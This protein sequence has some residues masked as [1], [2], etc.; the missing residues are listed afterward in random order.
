MHGVVSIE[1]EVTEV[2]IIIT[3]MCRQVV[4]TYLAGQSMYVTRTSNI[5]MY[6]YIIIYNGVTKPGDHAH[7]ERAGLDL[8]ILY[9]GGG[10]GLS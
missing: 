2:D 6:V 5:I 1:P 9:K 7:T 10:G 3:V 8:E 4:L